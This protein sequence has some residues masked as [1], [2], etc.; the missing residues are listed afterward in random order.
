MPRETLAVERVNVDGLAA[1]YTAANADGHAVPW[2]ESMLIHI[3][4]GDTAE[5]TIT[6][7]TPQT[8]GGLDVAERT[9]SIPAG[10]EVFI[11]RFLARETYRQDDGTVWIDYSATT[12]VD[13]AALR[14]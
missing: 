7:P 9:R 11:G 4:N 12:S 8:V 6:I 14:L 13:I 1:T 5:K 2:S 10:G 3:R